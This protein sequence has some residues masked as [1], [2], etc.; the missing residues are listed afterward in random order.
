MGSQTKR[1]HARFK[2]SFQPSN[3]SVFVLGAGWPSQIYTDKGNG[4][5]GRIH[6]SSSNYGQRLDLQSWGAGVVSA[7][8]GDLYNG[9]G[10]D[11]AYH[12]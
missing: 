6:M 2:A 7:G 11:A 5:A 10:D 3:R 9:E 4:P 8:Y 1:R 12:R